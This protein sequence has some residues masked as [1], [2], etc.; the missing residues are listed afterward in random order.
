MSN[1]F[2]FLLIAPSGSGKTSII[3][4][5]LEKFGDIK[6]FVTFTSRDPRPGELNGIDYFFVNPKQFSALIQSGKLIEW[7]EFY[8]QLYGS[9]LNQINVFINGQI[10]GIAAY[11]VLGAQRLEKLFP[12]NIITIFIIPPSLESIQKRLLSRYG[13]ESEGQSRIERFNMEMEFAGKF[14]YVVKNDEL[15][16]AFQNVESIIRAERCYRQA[17]KIQYESQSGAPQ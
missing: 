6:R 7:Q 10:D 9:S 11:D 8:G 17:R 14:K 1:G 5:I 13:N 16:T 3:T 2:I 12:K 4:K 15:E